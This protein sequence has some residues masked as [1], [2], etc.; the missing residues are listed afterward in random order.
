MKTQPQYR[1][2]DRVI[3]T[4]RTGAPFPAEI[5]SDIGSTLIEVVTATGRMFPQRTM[6]SPISQSLGQN[7][8]PAIQ[9][10]YSGIMGKRLEKRR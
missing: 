6:V 4:P 5:I 1:P 7:A 9:R 3:V 2:G 10:A 8:A